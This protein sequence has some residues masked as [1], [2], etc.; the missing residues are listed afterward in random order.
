MRI[1]RRNC[2][3]GQRDPDGRHGLS[4]PAAALGYRLCRLARSELAC[5]LRAMLGGDSNTGLRARWG[6][7]IV[8]ND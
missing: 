6:E 1:P 4:W 2:H 7:V 8:R 5:L 3:W